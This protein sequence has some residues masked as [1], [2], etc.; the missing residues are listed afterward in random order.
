MLANALLIHSIGSGFTLR[1]VSPKQLA[2]GYLS[3][4]EFNSVASLFQNSKAELA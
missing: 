4:Y 3:F 2:L 1:K